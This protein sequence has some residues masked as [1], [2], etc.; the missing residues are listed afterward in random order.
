MSNLDDVIKDILK[1]IHYD[2]SKSIYEQSNLLSEIG[3][4]GGDQ[5]IAGGKNS[6]EYKAAMQGVAAKEELENRK[7]SAGGMYYYQAQNSEKLNIDNSPITFRGIQKTLDFI[8]PKSK[9]SQI[10]VLEFHVTDPPYDQQKA[11]KLFGDWCKA[12]SSGNMTGKSGEDF[13]YDTKS[14]EL[15][16]C[17]ASTEYHPRT[18]PNQP[19]TIDPNFG[20]MELAQNPFT[21]NKQTTKENYIKNLETQ[22]LKEDSGLFG[23]NGTQGI[24]D[25]AAKGAEFKNYWLNLFG[26]NK[27]VEIDKRTKQ[28]KE[29][30]KRKQ[31]YLGSI[32]TDKEKEEEKRKDKLED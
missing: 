30:D 3:M 17:S 24:R 15:K 9:A 23:N 28:Q 18:L 14:P 22:I 31:D 1:N 20:L 11:V 25:A 32:K 16:Q 5:G 26:G 19:D 6:K 2:S 7:K 27:K 10:E 21:T 29:V 4:D 13:W 8:I 12:I